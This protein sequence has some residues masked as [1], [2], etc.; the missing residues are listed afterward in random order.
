VIFDSKVR[1]AQGSSTRFSAN[2]AFGI[3]AMSRRSASA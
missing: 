3:K 2:F 1:G